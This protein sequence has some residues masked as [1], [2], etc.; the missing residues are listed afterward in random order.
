LTDASTSRKES[1]IP[2][3]IFVNLYSPETHAFEVGQT[4]DVSC[5]GAR[6]LTRTFWKPNLSVSIRSIRGDFYSRGRVVHCQ[7]HRGSFIVG[8][9]MYYPE[10]NWATRSDLTS[11]G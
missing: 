7:R 6:V 10:G 9:E 8:L 11:S 1:R 4:S 3:K 5:H 2:L